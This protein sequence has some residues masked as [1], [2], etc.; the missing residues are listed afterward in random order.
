MKMKLHFVVIMLS[1]IVMMSCGNKKENKLYQVDM[2]TSNIS[3]D[4]DGTYAGIIP[5]ADCPGIFRMVA[6]G[7][8][9]YEMLNKYLERKG[10]FVDEGALK[11]VNDSILVDGVP[12]FVGEGMLFNSTDTLYKLNDEKNLPVLYKT[13][14]MVENRPAGQHALLNIYN[15]N[16]KQVVKFAFKG[17]E[18]QLKPNVENIQVNEYVDGKNSLQMEIIDPAPEPVTTPVFTDGNKSYEFTLLSPL[19]FVYTTS[20]GKYFDAVYFNNGKTGSVFLLT[21]KYGECHILPQKGDHSDT[22]VYTD[23]NIIWTASGKKAS[24]KIAGKNYDFV[25]HPV[26][27]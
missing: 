8:D 26:L 3:I 14:T 13:Q 16:G 15:K 2:H 7:F 12:Y 24:F 17:K 11:Q 20:E 9:K 21:D 5:A 23:G 10:L 27:K 6:L 19:N 22:T 4:V 1:G 18:Y 25:Q